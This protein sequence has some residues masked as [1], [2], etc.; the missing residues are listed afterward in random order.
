MLTCKEASFL[1][2]KKLDKNLTIKE[3]FNLSLH[4]TMCALCRHYAK[5]IEALHKLMQKMGKAEA[6]QLTEN[7]QLSKQAHERIKQEMDKVLHS[8]ER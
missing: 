7:K 2:S 8:A 3:H 1:A 6:T 5:E 4:L